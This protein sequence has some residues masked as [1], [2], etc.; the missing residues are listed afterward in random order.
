MSVDKPDFIPD[1]EPL[2]DLYTAYLRNIL[3]WEKSTG[4][5]NVPEVNQVRQ[6][7]ADEAN[8]KGSSTSP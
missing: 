1:P 4:Y 5:G 8:E 2:L 7:L 6:Q 3:P